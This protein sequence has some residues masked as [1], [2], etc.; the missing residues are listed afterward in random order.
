MPFA[1]YSKVE[2]DNTVITSR[3]FCT[4]QGISVAANVACDP[5]YAYLA[6]GIHADWYP[7]R[8]LRLAIEGQWVGVQTAFNDQLVTINKVGSR[9]AGVYTAKDQR[10]FRRNLPRPQGLLRLKHRGGHTAACAF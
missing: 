6:V 4:G 5:G 3:A 2:Y 7:V 9:P 10:R 1:Q 8:Q